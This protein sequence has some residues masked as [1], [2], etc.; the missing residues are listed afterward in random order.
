MPWV[1]L[2]DVPFYGEGKGWQRQSHIYK[3][4]F[5]Y[6][7]YCLAQTVA[8]EF[9]FRIRKDRKAAFETY[10]KYTKLGGSMLFTDLLKEAGLN[11]PFDESGIA[12]ICAEAERFLDSYDLAGIA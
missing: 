6:I 12:E 7:D 9:W 1:K 11:S 4:P 3:R 5:Y 8:L 2:D 10:M